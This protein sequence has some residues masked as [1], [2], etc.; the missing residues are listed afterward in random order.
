MSGFR[1]CSGVVIRKTP[2]AIVVEVDCPSDGADADLSSGDEIL[3][4]DSQVHDDSELYQL[5][6]EGD[7]V[8]SQWLARQ[9]EWIE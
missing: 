7:L 5:G 8:I 4:P 2:R 6:D 1:V 3:I 9:K